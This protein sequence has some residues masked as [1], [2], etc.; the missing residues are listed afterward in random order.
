VTPAEK[1]RARRLKTLFNLTPEEYDRILAFQQGV[2]ALCYRPPGKTRLAVDHNH[3]TGL[4][5]GLLCWTCNTALGKF[6]DDDD[7]V[8]AAA[9][10][11]NDPP[12][13]EALGRE[14]FG[15][16]GRTTNKKSTRKRA[17]RKRLPRV[18][19]SAKGT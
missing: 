1:A 3:K 13:T 19:T 2:C 7:R 11:V 16:L 17:E 18:N 14:V 8:N 15:V 12:A 9:Y 10:Y 6:R 4:V 5:R